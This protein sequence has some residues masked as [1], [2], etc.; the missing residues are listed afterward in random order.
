MEPVSPAPYVQPNPRI[1]KVLGILNIVFASALMICGLCSIGYYSSIPFFSKTMMKLQKDLQTKQDADRKAVLDGFE[2]EEK[3]ATT[4]EEKAVVDAKRKQYEAQPQPPRPPQMDLEVMGL[5]GSAIR[6]YVWAEFLSGLALN[7]LLLTAGI[8]LV[9]RRPW[10]IKLGLGVALLKIVRLVMVYGYA[11]LA[12]VPKLAVG[13]TKF[14]LQAMA[15]QPGGQKLPPGFGD[16]LTKGMLVWF[17]SCAVAMIVVGSI[18]P[19]VSLWLLSRP[20]AR[21][22]CANSTKTQESADTW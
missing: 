11:T 6:N 10:G 5:E 18:Y 19:L 3:D 17:T 21:A 4:D 14:Q 1:P 15:Q 2:Q 12:I 8:G 13:M 22:A 9:M 16:T 20:S 7:L